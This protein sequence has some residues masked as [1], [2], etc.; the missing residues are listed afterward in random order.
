MAI[1]V[2][3]SIGILFAISIYLLL[4]R[5]LLRWLLGTVILSSSVNLII[6]ISGRLHTSN[7]AFIP[8]NHVIAL[9]EV[10]NPLPQALIL[11]AIVIGFGLLIF[12][13]TLI[14]QF[15]QIE[16]CVDS[17]RLKLAEPIYFFRKKQ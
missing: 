12:A 16:D 13:L 4:S 8:A 9:Q 15:W 17:N 5:N 6:L 2:S 14:R 1:F 7:A 11:T 10:A 3:V